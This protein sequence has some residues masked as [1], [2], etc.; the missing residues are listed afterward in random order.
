MGIVLITLAAFAVT[1]PVLHWIDRGALAVA[2][3]VSDAVAFCPYCGNGL[4]G[5]IGAPLG[6]GRCGRE[7][8]V[9]P[10]HPST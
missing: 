10:T 2:I 4:S 3:G 1:V 6:C 7:F 8:R 5:G 9:T